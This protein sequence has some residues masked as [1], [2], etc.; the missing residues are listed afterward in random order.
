[1]IKL[2]I[3]DTHFGCKQ[4]SV[5]WFESQ[6]RLFEKQIIP[7]IQIMAG[8]IKIIHLGDVFDSRSSISTWIASGVV[9]IFKS[10]SRLDNVSEIIIING[11]HDFYSP[12]SDRV[13]TPSLILKDI[14]KVT[15]LSNRVMVDGDS[16]YV[17]WYEW[18]SGNYKKYITSEIKNI[19]THTDLVTDKIYIPGIRLLSGHI[20]IPYYDK[21]HQVYNLGSCYSLNFADANSIRGYYI[22]T[23]DD[24]V[25]MFPNTTGIN[26][27]RFKDEDIFDACE[28]IKPNDYVEMYVSGAN[29]K[30]EKYNKAIGRVL[31]KS[32]N[33]SVI[34]VIQEV[35]NTTQIDFNAYDIESI[36]RN[37]IPDRLIEKFLKI[38]DAVKQ[39]DN[40]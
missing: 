7:H 39:S 2:L 10:L 36:I 28:K 1:M 33:V 11:N 9:D 23:D 27:W 25:K 22:I 8:P 40:V 21:A 16:L 3:T 15:V 38:Q 26:F 12:N 37:F 20:H 18:A 19:F 5:T 32:K 17:P 6:K 14:P 35:Y 13:D 29:M 31:L 34:P 24:E 30:N 4:N